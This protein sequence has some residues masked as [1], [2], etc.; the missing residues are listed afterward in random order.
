MDKGV[1]VGG[2]YVEIPPPI[3]LRGVVVIRSL[4]IGARTV[5][6]DVLENVRPVVNALHP[7]GGVVVVNALVTVGGAM[8]VGTGSADDI[9]V[10]NGDRGASELTKV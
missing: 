2:E 6:V 7:V 8:V 3:E 1:T 9:V 5:D 4:S 10:L